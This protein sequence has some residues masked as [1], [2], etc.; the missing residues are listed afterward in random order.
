MRVGA[1]DH[2]GVLAVGQRGVGGKGPAAI[3]ADGGGA[4]FSVAVGDHHG[5]AGLHAAAI[6][7]RG[8]VAG[9]GA[10]VD[11][12][13]GVVGQAGRR[14]AGVDG[15]VDGAAA[16]VTVRVGAV[17]HQ[18]VL[19][20]SQR[21]VGGEGPAAV[22]AHGGGAELGVAVGDH[23]GGAGLH[24]AAADSRGGV[25]G[26]GAVGDRVTGI[27][28]QAGRSGAGVNGDVDGAAAG[29]AVCVGAVDHERVLAVIQRRVGGKGPAA[30]R[31][32]RG[33]TNYGLTIFNDYGGAGLHAAAAEGRGAV[34]GAAAIGNRITGIVDKR[35]CRARHLAGTRAVIP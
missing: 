32:R 35:W 24:A 12:D 1:V 13:T 16:G 8:G 27:V 22:L 33:F 15:D 26:R 7:R 2:E 19:A 6:D 11:R 4:E 14:G 25:A 23:H 5:G 9:R 17:N 10:V 21:R 29:V 20:V 3:L 31:T 18:R 30:V 28:G 34:A